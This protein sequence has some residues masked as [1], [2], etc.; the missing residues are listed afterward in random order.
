MDF[1]ASSRARVIWVLSS[2]SL[3]TAAV[4][5]GCGSDVSQSSSSGASTATGGG[6]STGAGSSV[7]GGSPLAC[8]PMLCAASDACIVD[9]MDAPC[10]PAPD[11]GGACPPGT[12]ANQCGGVGYPCC[13]GPTPPP[14][15]E[16]VSASAC[17]E[18]PSCD[19]LSDL[20]KD[21]KM[22]IGVA[23]NPIEL[24]CVTPPM[25]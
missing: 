9:E 22:C 18:G 10:S 5:A 19:C 7:G 12:T 6:S 25:P 17:I 23:G 4:F 11:D 20:C 16:C 1:I 15:Y 8:G 24:H 3:L 21:G 13:C 2:A 14:E